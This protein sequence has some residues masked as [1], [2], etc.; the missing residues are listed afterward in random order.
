MGYEGDDFPGHGSGGYSYRHFQ[1][2]LNDNG[3]SF[4]VD[5]KNTLGLAGDG[6]PHIGE[7]TSPLESTN[8]Y[9]LVNQAIKYIDNFRQRDTPFCFQL[10]FWGPHA[11]YLAPTEFLDLYRD[12]SFPPWPNFSD[13]GEKKS[14]FQ[15]RC[16]DREKTWSEW[17]HSLRHYFGFMSS[18]D[19]QIGRLT[20]Y[21]KDHSLYDETAIIFSAD[22]GDSQGCHGGLGDKSYH[23]Y[24]E[25]MR[26]PLFIK[27]PRPESPRLDVHK[28]AQTC[29]IYASILDLAGLPAEHAQHGR[30]LIPFTD[31][32]IP[33]DW[34]ESVIAEGL[35][36]AHSLCSHRM[37]RHGE[38]KYI[39]FASGTDELYNLKDDPWEV[40]NLINCAGSENKTKELQKLLLQWMIDTNDILRHDYIKL[41]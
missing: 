41:I 8:E 27:P 14:S 16:R 25:T 15:E 36:A 3:L 38:W 39:F 7:V 20:S 26:I 19:A 28:F 12:T 21:L 17:E 18:I 9:F 37:I 33:D 13:T 23:M 6:L 32:Q 40:T 10:N 35:S 31:G 29:D 5:G 11:P 34:R 1:D 30:S 24:Q 22:H 2:Y 4:D